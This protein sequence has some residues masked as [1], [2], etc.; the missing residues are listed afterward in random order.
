MILVIW[1]NFS[2]SS[3]KKVGNIAVLHK[4]VSVILKQIKPSFQ[5][6]ESSPDKNAISAVE[7]YLNKE[8]DAV[9]GRKRERKNENKSIVIL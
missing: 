9:I 3:L 5:S 6:N 2:V 8:W 4:A 7:M 1:I